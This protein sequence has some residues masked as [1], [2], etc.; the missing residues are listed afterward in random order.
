MKN[1]GDNGFNRSWRV[2][3]RS[4]ILNEIQHHNQALGNQCQSDCD[5]LMMVTEEEFPIFLPEC[6]LPEKEVGHVQS[7]LNSLKKLYGLLNVKEKDP[8]IISPENV[9][10]K[11]DEKTRILLK[12]LLDGATEQALQSHCKIISR[13]LDASLASKDLIRS[14]NYQ[15]TL[16]NNFQS[17]IP[18]EDQSQIKQT[19]QAINGGETGKFEFTATQSSK[20]RNNTRIC[21]KCNRK[22]PNSAKLKKNSNGDTQNLTRDRHVHEN[23]SD[24]QRQNPTR[25]RQVR[26]IRVGSEPHQDIIVAEEKPEKL[27]DVSKEVERA[28]QRIES[29]I[30]VGQSE[31]VG[32]ST[33]D[34][35]RVG[36]MI[37][38]KDMA[39]QTTEAKVG[40]SRSLPRQRIGQTSRKI[41]ESALP[42]Q[43]LSQACK[44]VLEANELP[45][46]MRNR[47]HKGTV[48]SPEPS[49]SIRDKNELAGPLISQTGKQPIQEKLDSPTHKA[50][51][52][53]EV[54]QIQ[55]RE[56]TSEIG[57]SKPSKSLLVV[58]PTLMRN[59]S[60]NPH[61]KTKPR[62]ISKRDPPHQITKRS[63]FRDP[64]VGP[65][66]SK[67]PS[68][69]T[70]RGTHKESDLRSNLLPHQQKPKVIRTTDVSDSYELT[71]QDT[72]T[73][74]SA[75]PPI[76]QE[77]ES[78]SSQDSYNSD[79][80]EDPLIYHQV[81]PT[82]R[83]MD[84]TLRIRRY[85]PHD[86][87]KDG[88]IPD[89][90]D[91]PKGRWR[92]F[93]DKFGIVL[94]HHHHHHHLHHDSS[95]E[96]QVSLA[97]P[98]HHRQSVGKYWRQIRD[99]PS[100]E[101]HKR[102][103]AE[104]YGKRVAGRTTRQHQL[105]YFHSLVVGFLRHVWHSKKSKQ[106]RLGKVPKNG[107]DAK[108]IHWWQK[109]NKRGVKLTSG[110]KPRVKIGFKTKTRHLQ[111]G[112]IS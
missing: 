3:V 91:H 112:K 46:Q 48:A 25:D 87:I 100:K 52:R 61:P 88:S 21:Q 66:R 42:D 45:S 43:I 86:Y 51:K 8:K 101:E 20:T 78:T 58:G 65:I 64:K 56:K 7:N 85:V 50:R 27:I 23:S 102:L 57:T 24:K 83:K 71:S 55:Q 67:G 40:T 99:R 103:M 47:I 54:D 110:K 104:I 75:D 79:S 39:T 6:G 105:G 4:K 29:E 53:K 13:Q 62:T 69:Q 92:R 60:L 95:D 28:I 35:V 44:A 22:R 12:K 37:L 82:S 14:G 77:M 2:L 10:I 32:I 33:N 36:P 84:P 49:K 107:K 97:A 90:K 34:R 68:Y 109:F 5:E 81:E 108:K 98:N 111:A 15:Q 9:S 74:E 73:D 72:Y 94:H 89:H 76:Y 1:V 63:S 38:K 30:N 59:D 18:E 31:K 80:E 93:K 16:E 96:I 106:S 19:S 41:K 17:Q 11:L 26:G 70:W